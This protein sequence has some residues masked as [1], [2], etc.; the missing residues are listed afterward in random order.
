V[1]ILFRLISCEPD[2]KFTVGGRVL[3]VVK[4]TYMAVFIGVLVGIAMPLHAQDAAETDASA[5]LNQ[6]VHVTAYI[7]MKLDELIARLGPP[8]SVYAGR[9]QEPWQDDVVFVYSEGDFFI[10]RDRVWQM[11]LRSAYGVSVGDTKPAAALALGEDATDHGDYFLLPLPPVGWPL[12]LRVHLNS[13]AR[14]SAIY[15]YRPDL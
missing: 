6:K 3:R 12:T 4:N 11:G 8:E 10:F 7:G 13:A 1:L 15:I 5:A 9:G 2:Y 14:V